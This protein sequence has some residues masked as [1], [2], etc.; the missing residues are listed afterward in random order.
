MFCQFCNHKLI[1]EFPNVYGTFCDH[2]GQFN[3]PDSQEKP[4][5]KLRKENKAINDNLKKI[6]IDKVRNNNGNQK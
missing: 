1:R 3:E 6:V 5:N 2:C 4:I